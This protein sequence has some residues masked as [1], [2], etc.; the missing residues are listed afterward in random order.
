MA[1]DAACLAWA[2]ETC[3]IESDR[4][5]E[6]ARFTYE[7]FRSR[8]LEL[9]RWLEREG[10]G[11]GD[12]FA[13]V[14][15]NQSRWHLSAFAA[16]H[17]GAVLVPLDYKLSAAEQLAL[18]AHSRAKLL[19]VEHHLWRAMAAA[20]RFDD[21]PCD[22]VLVTEA[23]EGTA[24]PAPARTR[25]LR[26]EECRAAGAPPGLVPRRK[27]DVAC[28]VYSSGTG[29]RPKG[30]LLTHGNYLAQFAALAALHPMRPGV[31][32]LSILPTN[33]AI[34]FMV[35]FLGPYLC[36]ASVVHLRTLRPELVRDAF[37]RYGVTHVAVVPL[38]LSNLETGLRER[39]AALSLPARAALRAGT[40][41]HALLGRG[42]PNPGLARRLLA[43]V[44]RA[45]GG[46]LEAVFVGGAWTDP[47]T[48]R[49]FHRLGIPVANGYGLTEAGT[50]I[51]LDR[52]DPPRPDTVGT[53]L[54]GVEVRIEGVGP[55]QVGEILVRGPTVM[56]GYLD[57]PELTAET[58]V[59]GWL[60]TGDL[61]R[62]EPDGALRLVGRRKNM[63]VTAG[64]KNV[65]PEDVETV[66][67]GVGA[68]E[69][70]IFA[71]HWLWKERV[72][73]E[74]LVLVARAEGDAAKD[75]PARIAAR[76]RALPD[77][78]RVAGIIP[79]ERDFPRTASLKIR[80]V[81]LA[82][83]VGEACDAERDL[84]RIP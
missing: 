29:G 22:I 75:L 53:P 33:H 10:L 18:L 63:I 69:I 68:K 83:Q 55:D 3:V 66:F 79:W 62:L 76:N 54:P 73:D 43:P 78:Q 19:V 35:G 24:L 17:R 80:R 67:E 71:A 84:V 59:D 47:E 2:N 9:A 40:V 11:G 49:F 81:E 36:G 8:A 5:R 77:W 15:S 39:F 16:F 31:T 57:D 34:D 21:L 1:L 25:V 27:G 12:R 20:P 74:R 65:Y 6:N 56:A 45:F 58:I 72:R 61:G 60:H 32:Y 7:E 44:H 38:V 64:G 46:R 13:I 51:T 70:C 52:L 30:C 28:I 42:R 37:A 23:P 14:L 41:L 82:R 50:A 4:G 26:W 48:I